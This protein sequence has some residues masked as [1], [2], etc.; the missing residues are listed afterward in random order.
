MEGADEA[1]QVEQPVIALGAEQLPHQ[2]ECMLLAAGFGP[3]IGQDGTLGV[4]KRGIDPVPNLEQGRS[5][6]FVM[7][8]KIPVTNMA[9]AGAAPAGDQVSA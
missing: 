1:R 5:S 8:M 6:T 3:V 7:C 4:A 9:D 2:T